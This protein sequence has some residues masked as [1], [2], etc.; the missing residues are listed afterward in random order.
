MTDSERA[1]E[2]LLG[3]AARRAE[4][5]ADVRARVL[6]AVEAEWHAGRR[7]RR[8]PVFAAAA[9]VALAILAGLLTQVGGGSFEVQLTRTES[10]SLDGARYLHGGTVLEIRSGATMAAESVSRLVGPG[11]TELRLRGGTV[12]TWIGPDQVELADGALYVDTHGRSGFR[13]A[14]PAGVVQDIGTR[15]MVTVDGDA[16]E[17]AMRE[18]ETRIDTARGSLVA[19]ADAAGGDVLRIDAAGATKRAEPTSEA[20]WEWIHDAH[21]GY[22]ERSVPVLL[23]RIADDLG[24]GLDYATPGVRAAIGNARMAGDLSELGPREALRV[25]V[26]TNGLALVEAPEG[27][28]VVALQSA[29]ESE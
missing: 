19:R 4:P 12:L 6:A 11:G 28:M 14:T 8:W 20:R 15:F 18:G 23:S 29:R 2:E 21:P 27:R 3:R 26:A 1:I 7:R 9:A 25:V 22:Q 5:P 13:V 10:L 16:V 17:V 24:V